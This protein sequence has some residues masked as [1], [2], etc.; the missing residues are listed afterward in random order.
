MLRDK[1]ELKD[2]KFKISELKS[3]LSEM[4]KTLQPRA[5]SN[6]KAGAS[7]ARDAG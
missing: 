1:E 3:E 4:K 6:L 2:S 5:G 7:F